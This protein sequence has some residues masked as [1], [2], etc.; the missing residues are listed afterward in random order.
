MAH[1]TTFSGATG[2]SKTLSLTRP[3]FDW[4]RT[5]DPAARRE[6]Q[7][8]YD[9]GDGLLFC[10]LRSTSSRRYAVHQA[11]EA[12]SDMAD[13]HLES[14][15]PAPTLLRLL[16]REPRMLDVGLLVHVAALQ[17]ASV[18]PRDQGFYPAILLAE[19]LQDI[20]GSGRPA[21]QLMWAILGHSHPLL[22]A[23]VR[24]TAREIDA[25]YGPSARWP[26]PL[27]A[28]ALR[29]AL[30]SLRDAW[31]QRSTFLIEQA[32]RNGGLQSDVVADFPNE[33]RAAI[34]RHVSSVNRASARSGAEAR[35]QAAASWPAHADAVLGNLEDSV[36]W[37][38]LY[39]AYLARIVSGLRRLAPRADATSVKALADSADELV[40]HD[41]IYALARGTDSFS[42]DRVRIFSVRETRSQRN[43]VDPATRRQRLCRQRRAFLASGI[44]IVPADWSELLA[45]LG[46]LYFG[47]ERRRGCA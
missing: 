12:L 3:I 27:K 37:L 28:R 29:A 14:S 34:A 38:R 32:R 24:R 42:H 22:V 41:V 20:L 44:E 18:M 35:L 31:T 17:R 2:C 25:G 11:I 39:I 33:D 5:L 30:A 36:G 47:A 10:Q 6:E 43:D 21:F 40:Q 15:A 46:N 4:L 9:V 16:I 1:D 23:E 13:E 19:L 7:S 26:T 45:E 8:L